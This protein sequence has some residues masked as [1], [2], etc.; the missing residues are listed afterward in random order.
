MRNLRNWI[1]GFMVLVFAFAAAQAQPVV[2]EADKPVGALKHL[3]DVKYQWQVNKTGVVIRLDLGETVPA[4]VVAWVGTSRQP[5]VVRDFFAANPGMRQKP[6]HV[7]Y[8]A[9]PEVAKHVQDVSISCHAPANWKFCQ[10]LTW[11]ER[12]ADGELNSGTPWADD[13]AVIDMLNGKPIDPV[14]ARNITKCQ[15]V[16]VTYGVVCPFQLTPEQEA[17]RIKKQLRYQPHFGAYD[18]KAGVI[19]AGYQPQL[20][21]PDSLPV[22]VYVDDGQGNRHAVFGD[23]PAQPRTDIPSME[24]IGGFVPAPVATPASAPKK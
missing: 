12:E 9:H 10:S 4:G 21:S 11:V 13:Q 18:A 17:L 20:V 2:R 23:G 22:Q 16:P 3:G 8:K 19:Y 15:Y 1:I 6:F 5:Q 7:F 14:Y 24:A